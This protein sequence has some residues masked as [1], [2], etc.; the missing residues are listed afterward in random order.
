MPSEWGEKRLWST[1]RERRGDIV[2]LYLTQLRDFCYPGSLLKRYKIIG[3][4][5]K[6]EMYRISTKHSSVYYLL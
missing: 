1:S 6:L 3:I 5:L 4:D 2:V